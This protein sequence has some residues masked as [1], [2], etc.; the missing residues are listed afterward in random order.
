MEYKGNE[1]FENTEG[2]NNVGVVSHASS[3]AKFEEAAKL[4]EVK[5]VIWDRGAHPLEQEMKQWVSGQKETDEF[6]REQLYVSS[7]SGNAARK[8]KTLHAVA[9][10]SEIQAACARVVAGIPEGK[11]RE[12]M[13]GDAETLATA[14]M[15]ACP[16]VAKLTLQVEI[17]GNNACSRWHQDEYVGRALITYVGPGTWMVDDE[18]VHF[19]QFEKTMD[20]P[21]E[22]SGPLIVP[23]SKSIYEAPPNAVTLIKGSLWP[24]IQDLGLT[25]KAPNVPK[26]AN[27][28]PTLKRVLL[29]V[30]L[31]SAQA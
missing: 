21:P 13:R 5:G 8:K 7:L 27:G 26:N 24:G 14:L 10:I 4:A 30:D 20:K 29:K 1:P 22:I 9:D 16:G 19:D 18:S 23:D 2:E 31:Q 11:L 28:S 25:H 3:M 17:V 12:S 6:S 15:R